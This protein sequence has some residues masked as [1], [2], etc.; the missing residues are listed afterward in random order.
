MLEKQIEK[1]VCDF[2]KSLGWLVIK[3][4]PVMNKGI[5]DRTFIRAGRVI[6]AEFKRAGGAVSPMQER[7]LTRLQEHGLETVVIWDVEQGLEYFRAIE[8]MKKER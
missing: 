1:K 8:D 3:N 6:F 7:W 2:A 5:P 4:N